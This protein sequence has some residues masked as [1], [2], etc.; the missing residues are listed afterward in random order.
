MKK[1]IKV[2]RK[3]LSKLGFDLQ[4]AELEGAC[5][6]RM[7][8]NSDIDEVR[9]HDQDGYSVG[10]IMTIDVDGDG[11]VMIPTGID[12]SRYEKNPVVLF[13]HNQEDPIGYA[14]KILVTAEDITAKT[15]YG[16][17]KQAQKIHQLVVDK[18]LRTHSIGFIPTQVLMRGTP[19]FQQAVGKLRSAYPAKFTQEK[20]DRIRRIILK[21]I[22][23]EY[24][25]VTIP[26]N[27]DAVM[28]EVKALSIAQEP[29][30]QPQDAPEADTQDETQVPPSYGALM[31]ILPPSAA[32]QFRGFAGMVADADIHPDKPRE[33]E[34]HV[35]VKYGLHTEDAEEIQNMLTGAG[36]LELTLGKTTLFY[37]QDEVVLKVDVDCPDLCAMNYLLSQKMEHTD[38]YEEYKPHITLAYL[39][40]TDTY[41]I[42][43]RYQANLFEGEKVHILRLIYEAPSGKRTEIDLTAKK[44]EPGT[45]TEE[46]ADVVSIPEAEKVPTVDKQEP[47]PEET[48]TEPAPG[49]VPAEP[50][51][52]QSAPVTPPAAVPVELPM[53][54]A[55]DIPE[56]MPME[57]KVIRRACA[58][59][60]VSTQEER[61]VKRLQDIYVKCWGV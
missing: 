21:A 23:V 34:P 25:I 54:M 47:A 43:D 60:R 7:H 46:I 3:Y 14:E 36:A 40:P 4:A 12:I 58:I 35:T 53:D 37:N 17:T 6:K 57:I 49:A 41:E 1:T 51:V 30:E 42:Y 61:E 59:K 38:T 27:E 11:D 32:A 56:P 55:G 26:A 52:Q 31:G 2:T 19:G 20:I 10:K 15:R 9:P 5:I 16:T 29:Q 13:N 44:Q 18:V 48:Y 24:S 22:L 39:K 33:T 45:A 8:Y 50:A 28:S